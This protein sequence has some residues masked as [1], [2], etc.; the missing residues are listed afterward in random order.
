MKL[1]IK[2]KEYL[3]Y[4]NNRMLVSIKEHPYYQ[5]G[6]IIHTSKVTSVDFQNN[7]INTVSNSYEMSGDVFTPEDV[8]NIQKSL[9]G[10]IELRFTKRPISK[11]EN[12][13]V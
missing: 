1:L 10:E 4:I 6:E 2:I 5:E 13:N 12:A 3:G 9:D 8:I 7:V 11:E